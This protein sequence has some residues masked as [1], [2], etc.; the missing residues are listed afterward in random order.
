MEV[1]EAGGRQMSYKYINV[2]NWRNSRRAQVAG[3]ALSMSRSIFHSPVA[4]FS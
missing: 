1:P 4:V 3:K 2:R